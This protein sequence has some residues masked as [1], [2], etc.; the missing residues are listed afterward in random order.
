[1]KGSGGSRRARPSGGEVAPDVGLGDGPVAAV[2][3]PLLR[4]GVVGAPEH[5]GDVVAGDPDRA[6][7]IEH[8]L[9]GGAAHPVDQEFQ[10]G[11]GRSGP[12]GGA[13]RVPRRSVF[14]RTFH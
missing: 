11:P 14:L 2:G 12:W 5:G 13:V 3:G 8:G 6:R 9:G 10:G 4:V 1:M 7:I